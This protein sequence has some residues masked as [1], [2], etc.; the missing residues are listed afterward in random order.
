MS[1]DSQSPIPLVDLRAQYQSISSG[2]V[3]AVLEGLGECDFI[4]GESVGTFESEFAEYCEVDHAVSCGSGTD[5]LQLALRAID[6]APGDEVIIPAFTFFATGLAVEL[7]GGVPVLADVDAETGLLD[8]GALEDAITANTK[9][10]IP[11]HLYGQCAPMQ[12]IREIAGQYGL[13][14]I[15]DAAQAHGAL[16][17]G[18]RAGS[19]GDLACFSFYPGK[20]LGAYGDGGAVTTDDPHLADKLR[21]LRNLGSTIKYQHH[22]VGLNSRL[23][24]LQ[25]RVLRAKLPLLD[26]WNEQRRAIAARYDEAFSDH[27]ELRTLSIDARNL[28]VHHLY[29]LRAPRRDALVADLNAAGIGAGVHYPKAMHRHEA[30]GHHPFRWRQFRQAESWAQETLSLPMYPE[31]T[32]EQQERVI[33]KTL[34]FSRSLDLA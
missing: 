31:L 29:V 3:D 9:A 4:L 18:N 23:D 15:E 22:L 5:A 16:H 8:P 12:E 14:V 13:I 27:P 26:T 30:F 2:I 19:L 6:L 20:N 10:I 25:A 34:E 28:P 24:T 33:E 21:S 7:A 1:N 17:E 11:V 32:E